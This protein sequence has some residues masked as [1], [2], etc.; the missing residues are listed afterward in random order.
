LRK[1]FS[2]SRRVREIVGG[3][4]GLLGRPAGVLD[5]TSL[6]QCTRYLAQHLRAPVRAG[7]GGGSLAG[8][9]GNLAGQ[10]Q[11]TCLSQ[12]S[13]YLAERLS[14]RPP[15][16]NVGRNSVGLLELISLT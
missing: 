3:L 7:N 2:A 5:L 10:L 14:P 4:I 13:R 16:A 15:V 8:L 12:G 1:R 6:S 11:L 9:F